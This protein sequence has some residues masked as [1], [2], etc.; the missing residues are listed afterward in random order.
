MN[1]IIYDNDNS[2]AYNNYDIIVV[3]AHVFGTVM[4]LHQYFSPDVK[5]DPFGVLSSKV[6]S[7]M[8]IEVNKQLNVSQVEPRK[9][10]EYAKFSQAEKTRI[11]KYASEHGVSKALRH[12]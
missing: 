3:I 4:S 10:G 11:A 7:T 9:R 5:L 2:H 8:I 1:I 12:F 6:P